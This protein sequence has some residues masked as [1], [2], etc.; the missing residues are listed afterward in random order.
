M[1]SEWLLTPIYTEMDGAFR[2]YLEFISSV[3]LHVTAALTIADQTDSAQEFKNG[4]SFSLCE[5]VQNYRHLYDISYKGH[6]DK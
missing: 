5:M 6:C 4:G 1:P 3:I 2:L